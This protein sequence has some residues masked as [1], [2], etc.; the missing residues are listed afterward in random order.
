MNNYFNFGEAQSVN[1]SEWEERKNGIEAIFEETQADNF[2]N[3]LKDRNPHL[4]K[5][6]ISKKKPTFRYK[7][8]KLQNI[9]DKEKKILSWNVGQGKCN[10]LK[11][12]LD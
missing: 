8:E 6:K 4:Q 1:S 9:K 12:G 5:L 3:L 10:S 7:I 2:P 11:E